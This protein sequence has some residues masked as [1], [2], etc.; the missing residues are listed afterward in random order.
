MFSNTFV[1]KLI[2]VMINKYGDQ[3]MFEAKI[4][5]LMKNMS[6][7]NKRNSQ[8]FVKKNVVD[9]EKKNVVDDEQK[10]VINDEKNDVVDETENIVDDGKK[11]LSIMQRKMS[12]IK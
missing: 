12:M 4:K 3:A 7:Q 10:N 11:M 9:V 8:A 1:K 6:R 5:K 2:D